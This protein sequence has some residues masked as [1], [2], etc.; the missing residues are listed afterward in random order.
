MSL[1]GVRGAITVEKNT[2]AEILA[3]TR[4]L[5][6]QLIAANAIKPEDIASALFSTTPGLDAAFPAEAARGLG[7]TETPLLCMQEI[8]VPG[9][10]TNCIRVL[11]H[12]NTERSQ[13]E[14]KHVYLRAAVKLRRDG[15]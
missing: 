3:A 4:E 9:S 15:Q 8:P 7:W 5:L 12:L 14:M 2:K 1:R 11:I 6:E 10:L 13:Q